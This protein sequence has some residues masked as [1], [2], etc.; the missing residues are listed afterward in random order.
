MIRDHLCQSC[1]Q[2]MPTCSGRK[3]VFGIDLDPTCSGAEADRVIKCDAYEKRA[4]PW[5]WAH[6]QMIA[7][8]GHVR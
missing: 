7:R 6:T 8:D 5:P 4:A 1:R 3:I 2:M